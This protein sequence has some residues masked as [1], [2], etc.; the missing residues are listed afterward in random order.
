MYPYWLMYPH[1]WNF[2]AACASGAAGKGGWAASVDGNLSLKS[3]SN[4]IALTTNAG[5]EGGKCAGCTSGCS[6]VWGD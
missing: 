3:I 6:Y 1:G 4:Q 5:G 2:P